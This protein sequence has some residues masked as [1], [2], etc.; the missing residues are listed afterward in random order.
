M[1]EIQITIEGEEADKAAEDLLN[2]SGLTGK[3]ESTSE[4]E[5]YREGTLMTIAAIVGIVGGA[6]ALAE[7]I[8]QWYLE[9]KNSQSDKRISVVI[10]TPSGRILMENATIKEISEA[11]KVLER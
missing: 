7:Q 10:V 8:R 11:L 1:A 3:L 5:S 9:Y 4:E 6:T 2:I